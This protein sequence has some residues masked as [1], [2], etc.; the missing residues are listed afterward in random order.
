MRDRVPQRGDIVDALVYGETRPAI[1]TKVWNEYCVDLHVFG[2]TY[3][4]PP[5]IYSASVGS[6]WRWPEV[7]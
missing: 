5:F 3:G 4:A 6:Q 7:E 1:V 2:D